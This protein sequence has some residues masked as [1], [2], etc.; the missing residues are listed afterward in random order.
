MLRCLFLCLVLVVFPVVVQATEIS[1]AVVTKPGS[2]QYICAELFQKFVEQR[3]DGK[4]TVTFHHS[5]SLGSETDILQQ[6]Q[7][8]AINMAIVTTGPLDSFIPTFAVLDYPFLFRNAAQADAV[9][10]GPV[11]GALL[12][13]LQAAGFKGL[14]FS[15]NGFRHL[16]T[17]KR[18]VTTP[19]DVQGL[20]V[21]VM[22][23][24]LHRD[25]WRTL[26]ANPTPMAWPIYAELQ[27]GTIDAQENPL[28]AI[29]EYRL[30]EVQSH[31]SLTGHVYSAHVDLANLGWFQSLPEAT[32]TLLATAMADAAIA[33][34]AETRAKDKAYL[35]LLRDKGM[36][37]V[38][39]PD[40]TA[41]RRKINELRALP[42][43]RSPAVAKAL[44]DMLT[45]TGNR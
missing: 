12:E 24:Q 20:K 28:W 15:E 36:T 23:S 11:G 25:L 1:L 31:L 45:A 18:A 37:I 9:L 2:A 5:A 7:L 44:D 16:T 19:D 30:Y 40:T 4:L 8:G 41:F 35:Q 27:Q 39:T 32:R 6:V 14:H 26:G 33:Q 10:D 3:S 34:R 38:D 21:R 13:D 17:G 22:E 42:L 43:F 29:A